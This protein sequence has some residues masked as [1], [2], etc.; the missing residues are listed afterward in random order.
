MATATKEAAPKAA[1]APVAEKAKKEK[2]VYQQTF[3]SEKEL[4]EGVAKRDKGPRRM[5]KLEQGGKTYWVA[6]NNAERAP[7]VVFRA[8]G[9]TVAELGK[10]QRASKISA[11]ALLAS[12]D[13]QSPEELDR[14][15]AQLAK[16]VALRKQA[17]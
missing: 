9:G 6:A 7:A 2:M 13:F 11:D 4:V 3:G 16:L 10:K 14:I 15:Q 1:E 17:K 12:L 8:I 5:F